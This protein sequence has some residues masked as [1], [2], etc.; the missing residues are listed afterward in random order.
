VAPTAST[1]LERYAWL[2][3]AAAIAT[4]SLKTLAWWLT[5]SVGLLSDALESVVNLA[6]GFLALWMLRLAASPPSQEHPYGYSKAEY[7][8]AGIEGALIV[9]AAAGILATAIPR[10][11]HPHV[12]EMP[13]W[14][15]ALSVAATA[16]NL[17]VSLV[18][19]RAGKA[20]RSITLEAD[21][22]H[23]MTDVWTSAGVILGVGLVF[24]TG[25]LLL[26]PLLALAVA[27]QIVWTG[28]GLMRRSV[29]GLLD[30]AI[31]E[32]DRAEIAKIFSEYSRRYRLSFHAL[33][34]RRAAARSFIS[35]HLLV[36]DE[37]SVARAHRLSEEIE[38]RIREL[39]EGASID[40]H[41]EPISDPA[42]YEDQE[43]DR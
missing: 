3:V 14:G 37:W 22:R 42:S 30:S 15:L 1:R 13:G 6:A 10:L 43:L 25:W 31:P 38:E 35:F 34:T 33:R 8:S 41:I 20:H 32:A 19:I 11:F 36:P 4:I 24:A 18:L 27:V 9:L 28:L 12:L 21:G 39:I 16:I 40:V 7:F 2:S 26:D 23:L 5:G 29:S 17:A